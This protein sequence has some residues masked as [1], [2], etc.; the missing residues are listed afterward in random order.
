MKKSLETLISNLRS[1]E[2]VL[3][4]D[5]SQKKPKSVALQS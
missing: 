5:A 1:Y 4:A 2:M 3:N